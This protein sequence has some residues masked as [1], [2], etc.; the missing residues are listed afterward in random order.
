[1]S[2]PKKT[3]ASKKC[4]TELAAASMNRCTLT[5]EHALACPD[6][7]MSAI[8]QT[9]EQLVRVQLAIDDLPPSPKH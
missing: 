3:E 7:A 4:L 8:K 1:M 2:P 6:I 9:A 5:R